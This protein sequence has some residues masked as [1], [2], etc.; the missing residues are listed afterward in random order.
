MRRILGQERSPV[1]RHLSQV[2]LPL[3]RRLQR[4]SLLPLRQQ[5]PRAPAGGWCALNTRLKAQA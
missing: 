5:L 2:E 3:A 1:L 4:R